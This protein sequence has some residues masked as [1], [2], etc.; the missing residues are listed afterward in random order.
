MMPTARRRKRS[1]IRQ[2]RTLAFAVAAGALVFVGFVWMQDAPLREAR[3][4]LQQKKYEAA[5]R[6]V[7]EWEREHGST[8]YSQALTAQALVGLGSHRKALRIFE[9]IGAADPDELHAWATA[10]LSMEQWS[11]A[12]PLLTDLHLRRPDDPDVLHE[13]AACQAQLGMYDDAMKSAEK[14]R[15]LGSKTHRAMLLIGSIHLKRGNKAAALQ[16]WEEIAAH[17]PEYLDLQLPPEEFLTQLASLQIEQGNVNEADQLLVQ[18]LKI[19]ETAEAFFQHGLA[20]DLEGNATA[21]KER[22]LNA[23]KLDTNH[24]NARESLAR[25]AITRGDTDEAQQWLQPLLEKNPL[26]SS[27][28]Y[29]MQRLAQS[30]KDSQQTAYWQQQVEDLRRRETMDASVN[31]VLTENPNSFWAHIIRSYQFAEQGN[32]QQAKLLLDEVRQDNEDPFVTDLR[33]AV[34]SQGALPDKNRLPINLF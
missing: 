33:N 11:N 3:Q 9:Q 25:Q 13:L 20:A 23:L 32:F 10:Y 24:L 15:E 7:G 28:A 31:R 4:L 34:E 26:R 6:Q 16:A 8:E 22:W 2:L 5:H 29:L 18:A 12:L 27:T 1:W 21:A 19:R 17:D 14:F 30:K